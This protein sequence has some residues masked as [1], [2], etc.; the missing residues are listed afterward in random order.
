MRN[1]SQQQG[2]MVALL[3]IALPVL[4]GGVGMVIDT[5]SFYDLRRRVQSAADAAAIA[6]AQEARLHNGA[7]VAS[8]ARYDAEEDRFADGTTPSVAVNQPPTLGHY[9][10]DSD[11]V[12]VI[13][14]A[15][16][17]LFFMSALTD[18]EFTVRGRAV[19][20]V[21]G[22]SACA[23]TLDKTA[24]HSF[25]ATG[26]SRVTF[27]DCGVF[28]NSNDAQA[29]RTTGSATVS[30]PSIDVVGGFAGNGFAPTPRTGASQLGDPFAELPMPAVGSCN[31]TNKKVNGTATLTP[32]VYCGGI[33]INAGA[34][35]TLDPGL[36]VVRGGGISISSTATVAGDGVTFFNTG[37]ASYA[38]DIIT[39]NGGAAVTLTAPSSGATK[40][41]LFFDDRAYGAS[42]GK[43]H[44]FNGGTSVNLTG[45]MYFAN[46]D[47]H[48]VGNFTGAGNNMILVAKNITIN[49][50]VDFVERDVDAL[51]PVLASAKVVE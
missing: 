22:S 3:A 33:T 51:P 13:V 46:T 4:L 34:K 35:V 28:V 45:A 7:N 30:A 10:G 14:S 49:G 8:S 44:T 9:K 40:G 19:A 32:G 16:A 17:P 42:I 37:G 43:K 23:W 20:G 18:R 11:Y 31:Y 24:K 6:A 29:A 15:E 27:T 26:T 47:L 1:T 50:N 2:A 25:D 38:Y 36:Y 41:I 39:V 5:G 21:T 48:L 12:E